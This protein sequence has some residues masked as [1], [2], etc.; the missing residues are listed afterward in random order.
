[1]LEPML[2]Y[3]S[4]NRQINYLRISVTDR[5]NFR[6]TYCMPQE[7]VQ[8]IAHEHILRYEEIIEFVRI[9]VKYGINKIRITGGEPLVRKGIVQF[10]EMLSQIKGITDL[11]LTTNGFLLEE[12]APDIKKA[13]IHR[14]NISLDT[15]NSD[16]FKAITRGGS[17]DKVVNGILKAKELGFHPIKINVVKGIQTEQE[18]EEL[19]KFALQHHLELRFIQLMNLKH[20]VFSRVEGGEGGACHSCNRLRLTAD[21]YLMPCLFNDIKYHIRTYG[22]EEALLKAV[23]TKPLSGTHN[24]SRCFYNVGG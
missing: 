24:L 9:A 14:I 21:G 4:F 23:N 19:K 10:I 7:G 12:M 13:G 3:D 17:V 2:L 22:Y 1:M 6:C 5:C 15:L 11:S 16:N 20:G 18:I 8:H